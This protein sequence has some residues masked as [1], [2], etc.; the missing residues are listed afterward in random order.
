MHWYKQS[1]SGLGPENWC[2]SWGLQQEKLLLNSLLTELKYLTNI[3]NGLTF[4]CNV[5]QVLVQNS[6]TAANQFCEGSVYRSFTIDTIF[7]VKNYV[8]DSY[9]YI[10]CVNYII[11]LFVID[12]EILK[13][14]CIQTRYKTGTFTQMYCQYQ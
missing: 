8:H 7:G 3:M 9:R 5:C 14:I 11:L 12:L 4:F 13:S 2:F 10:F 1:F 6:Q